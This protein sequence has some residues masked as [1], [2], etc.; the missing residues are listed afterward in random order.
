M[1]YFKLAMKELFFISLKFAFILVQ[2]H[3]ILGLTFA[4][5]YVEFLLSEGEP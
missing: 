1:L 4:R 5:N 2:D 3:Y